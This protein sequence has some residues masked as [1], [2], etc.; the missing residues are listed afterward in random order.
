M[1]VQYGE[2]NKM[3]RYEVPIRGPGLLEVRLEGE[4]IVQMVR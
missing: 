2:L 1:R 4:I 3:M